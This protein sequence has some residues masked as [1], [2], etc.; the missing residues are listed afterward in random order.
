[1]VFN[2]NKPIMFVLRT[3][4]NRIPKEILQIKDELSAI[5]VS[6]AFGM[7]AYEYYN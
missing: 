3:E 1:M 7:V 4:N 6:I 5:I 2:H